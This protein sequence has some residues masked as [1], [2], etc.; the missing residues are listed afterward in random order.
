MINK[1]LSLKSKTKLE[2]YKNIS[3]FYDEMNTRNF[4]FEHDPFAQKAQSISEIHHEV[5]FF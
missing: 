4:K 5:L 3:N 2:I 1:L